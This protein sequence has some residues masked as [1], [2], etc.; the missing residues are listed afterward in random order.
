MVGVAAAGGQGEGDRRAA[1]DGGAG[2]V[3]V[4]KGAPAGQE[5]YRRF[6]AQQFLDHPDGQVGLA[7]QALPDLRVAQQGEHA[8]GDEVDGRFV[9]GDQQQRGVGHQFFAREPAL[10]TIV[11]HQLGEH[12]AAT[13]VT[14]GVGQLAEVAAQLGKG[15]VAA[16]FAGGDV[17]GGGVDGFDDGVGPHPEAW[18]VLAGY[19]EQPADNCDR[20]GVGEVVDE[21]GLVASG[22]VVDQAADDFGQIGEHANDPVG[23]VRRPEMPGQQSPYPVVLGR[24]EGDE[25]GWQPRRTLILAGRGGVGSGSCRRRRG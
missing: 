16:A 12:V 25:V 23:V 14:V 5:L 22:E 8:V 6:V 18:F 9:A 19:P 24:V 21:V 10:R 2:D 1:G 15:L 11:G 3:D 17:A 4:V 13:V 20:E 7:A